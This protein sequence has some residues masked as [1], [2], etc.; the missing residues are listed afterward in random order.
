MK[1][2]EIGEFGLIDRLSGILPQTGKGV[3]LAVGDDCAVL[4]MGSPSDPERGY[5][6][7]TTDASIENRH[8]L[9]WLATPEQIGYKIMIANLSDVASMGAIPR[10]ATVSLSAPAD[11]SVEWTE[12]LYRGLAAAAAASGAV[13]VG[14]NTTR[15]PLGFSVD[16]GLL[17]EVERDRLML[18][19]GARPGDALLVTDTIGD[20]Y[21]GLECVFK[22]RVPVPQEARDHLIHRYV[23]PVARIR[24]GRVISGSRLATT[25]MDVSDGLAGDVAHICEQSKAGV[26]LDTRALPISPEVRAFAA[27]ARDAGISPL[28][29]WRYALIGGDDYGLLLTCP[30]RDADALA[31]LVA[32]ETG[33]TLTRIGT[34]TPPEK[35]RTLVLDDGRKIALDIGSW[36]HFGGE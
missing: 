14:G 26:E 17:G 27:A 29:A 11:G 36:Q 34:I 24:E 20:A 10:F 32:N 31:R 18:R 21:C 5:W 28:P 22:P 35:G 2:H 19:S 9:P 3:V 13:I 1:L 23:A 30:E 12:G 8:Y 15:S 33:A 6:V 7:W 16:I 25:M 4:D